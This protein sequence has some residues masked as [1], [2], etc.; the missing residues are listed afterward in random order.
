MAKR[1]RDDTK[2]ERGEGLSLPER[3]GHGGLSCRE[4]SEKVANY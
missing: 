2:G 4:R 1:E 3:H